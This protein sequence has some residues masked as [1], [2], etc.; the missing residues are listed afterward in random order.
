MTLECCILITFVLSYFIRELSKLPERNYSGLWLLSL[1]QVSSS[2]YL[3][4]A[5]LVVVFTKWVKGN[6]NYNLRIFNSY[7]GLLLPLSPIS[8]VILG[9]D[10]SLFAPHV[11][12][13]STLSCLPLLPSV[14]SYSQPPDSQLQLIVW[15]L[16]LVL[17]TSFGIHLTTFQNLS[18]A[19]SSNYIKEKRN[20]TLKTS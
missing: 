20:L 2:Y 15:L 14:H 11:H 17:I 5:I 13:N 3:L 4:L 10:Y 12:D 9:Y 18:T 1:F 7:A 6:F 8:S 19:W 16:L